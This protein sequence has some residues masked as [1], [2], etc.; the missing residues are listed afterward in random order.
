MSIALWNF[1]TR[2]LDRHIFVISAYK[3]K[4]LSDALRILKAYDREK[5]RER[6]CQSF[7]S[8]IHNEES[9][10]LGFQYF[11]NLFLNSVE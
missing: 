9:K 1:S 7:F 11:N 4:S 10:E 2:L 5:E 3:I 8:N 6:D